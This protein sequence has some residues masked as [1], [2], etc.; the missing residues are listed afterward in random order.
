MLC[1]T[2]YEFIW[3][4]TRDANLGLAMDLNKQNRSAITPA[5][6]RSIIGPIQ[7]RHGL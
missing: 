7:Y 4:N 3:F 5:S 2:D 6:V 1:V